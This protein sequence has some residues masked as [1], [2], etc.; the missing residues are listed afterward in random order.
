MDIA[1]TATLY[2]T[3]ILMGIGA[4]GVGQSLWKK[5]S[6]HCA[7]LGSLIS[8][9]LSTISLIENVLMGGMAVFMLGI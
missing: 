7:C 2:C 6:L 4:V 1:E 9:P 8:V 3:A 5:S